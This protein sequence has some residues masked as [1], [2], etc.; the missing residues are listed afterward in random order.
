MDEGGR[1]ARPWAQACWWKLPEYRI[2]AGRIQPAC[3][4]P[5]G[6]CGWGPE[7]PDRGGVPYDPLARRRNDGPQHGQLL[8]EHLRDLDTRSEQHILNFVREWGL[9]GLCQHWMIQYRG[10]DLLRAADKDDP[11]AGVEILE[12]WDF[13]R[14][15]WLSDWRRPTDLVKTLRGNEAVVLLALPGA[16]YLEV[17]AAEYIP[18]YFPY[19]LSLPRDGAKDDPQAGAAFHLPFCFPYLLPERQCEPLQEFKDAVKQFQEA[20]EVCTDARDGGHAPGPEIRGLSAGFAATD[21]RWWLYRHPGAGNPVWH[22]LELHLRRVHLGPAFNE[23]RWD[24]GWRF[25]SLLSVAYLQ[26]LQDFTGGRLRRCKE[27]LTPF[28]VG[29][30]SDQEYCTPACRYRANQRKYDAA[31]AAKKKGVVE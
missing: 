6:W 8:W 17:P 18:R 9:L 24:I 7:T 29:R 14:W 20:V 12:G 11:Q 3:W 10:A 22:A 30:R 1:A 19:V 5:A 16:G 25:P 27:C 13:Q 26:L 23:G 4:G 28:R 31:K 2:E 15:V 21:S